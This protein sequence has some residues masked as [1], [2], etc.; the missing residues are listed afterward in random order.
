VLSELAKTHRAIALDLPGYGLSDKP[1]DAPP[2]ARATAQ[3]PPTTAD[4]RRNA[5]L[6]SKPKGKPLTYPS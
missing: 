2:R 4:N 3:L 5:A 6:P 1:R